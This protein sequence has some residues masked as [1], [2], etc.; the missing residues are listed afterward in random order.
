MIRIDNGIALSR[1]GVQVYGKSTNDLVKPIANPSTAFGLAPASGGV[2]EIRVTKAGNGTISSPAILLSNLG[3]SWDGKV[4]RPLIIETFRTTQGRVQRDANGALVFGSLP[5]SSNLAFY[6][7][8]TKGSAGT[9]GNYANNRYFPRS[10]NPSRCAPDMN[11]CPTTET[12]GIQFHAGTWRTSGINPDITTASRLHGDGDVHAGDGPPDA[13]GNPTILPGGNGI[14]VPFPGSKG[15]RHF[16]N[17]GYQYGNLGAWLTQDT[18]DI[19]EWTGG[20]GTDEHNQSRSGM[21]AYGN[22]TDPATVPGTGTASYYGFAYGWYVP[23]GSSEASFYYGTA[24][25]SVNFSN[26]QVTISIQNTQTYDAAATPVPATINA[27]TYMGASSSNVA[28]YLTGATNNGILSGGVSGRYFG[29][30]VS[31][32]LS[33][34]SP[35]E[36]GGAYTLSSSG[37]GATVVGGFLARRQ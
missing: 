32:G 35:A 27:M 12:S 11:P 4:E 28:G 23:N 15:Y 24:T 9:Q 34:P 6:D 30:V 13:N 19:V 36:L 37:S 22:V 7:F 26:R 33:G 1:S 3:I 20:A 29:P 5:A 10:G 31:G 14:G 16:S 2:A 8:G 18:V 17:W 25:M 21:V